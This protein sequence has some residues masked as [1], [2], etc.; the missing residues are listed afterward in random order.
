LRDR[1]RVLLVDD[2]P[3]ARGLLRLLLRD[4]PDVTVVGECSGI[5]G[6]G[7][8]A[9]AHPDILFLD[10]QMPEMDGFD[11]LEALGTDRAPVVVFVTA[12]DRYAVRAF[13]VHAVD[14]L[15][16]PIDDGRFAEA[17]GRAKARARARRQG[18]ADPSLA[19]L[20]RERARHARRFLVRTRESTIVVDTEDID[21]IEANDYYAALHVGGRS[22][23]LRETMTSLARRLDPARFCR[24][25]RSAI[26]NLA[27]VR[28]IHA[29]FRGDGEIV[30]STGAR[31]RL[32]RTRRGELERLLSAPSGR[33]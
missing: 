15:L 22:H 25:H 31:V 16:K 32:S 18:R 2:E 24:V 10:V 20:V 21:W 27:R 9:R 28:E 4:D 3:L 1:L 29:L 12:Y 5:D 19:G 23:L 6:V 26:V 30:L 13:Q 7:A 33:T 17:L 8:V 11:L 14:Y